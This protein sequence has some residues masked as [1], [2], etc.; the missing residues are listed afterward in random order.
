V[1][2]TLRQLAYFVAAGEAESVTLA[3]QRIRISQPTLSTAI[4]DLERSLGL[5]LFVRHHAQGISLTPAGQEFLREANELLRQAAELERFALELA[6]E[7][8]G[9]LELGC[10]VTLAPLVA[11]RLCQEF[12]AAHPEVALHLVEGGQDELLE[13]RRRGSLS[14]ALT[15]DL[16]L[17][18]EIAFEPLVSLPPYALFAAGHPFAQRRSVTL[19]ELAGEPLIL[20]DLPLSREYFLSLFLGA[21]VE[22]QV[23]LRSQHLDVIRSLVGNGYGYTLV[24]AR[25]RLDRAP[26]G[27]PLAAV[28]LRGRHRALDL[29]MASLAGVRET[30]AVT[31]FRE[32]CRRLVTPAGVPGILTAT[33]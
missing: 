10:L 19:A 5:Q 31:A 16:Q 9:P 12:Q 26:D 28:R 4:R 15:Y 20:L 33:A 18:E 3:A 1:R 17:A 13:Q 27:S 22:P 23:R 8:R 2:L 21:G 32:H 11:P 6:D 7:V 29:G 30:R 25:P 24:N 14:L